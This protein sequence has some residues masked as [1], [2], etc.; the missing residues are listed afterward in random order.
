[1]L[2]RWSS[3]FIRRNDKKILLNKIKNYNA[4]MH[5]TIKRK[6]RN[7]TITRYKISS[8]TIGYV[9]HCNDKNKNLKKLYLSHPLFNSTLN[10]QFS[11]L[12]QISGFLYIYISLFWV[13]HKF[14]NLCKTGKQIY[15]FLATEKTD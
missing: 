13:R 8:K 1:M 4:K 2:N 15:L 5:R 11:L 14:Q 9:T 7:Q 6:T 3:F 10:R 12:L